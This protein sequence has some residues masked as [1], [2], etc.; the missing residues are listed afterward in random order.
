[1][2]ENGT[3]VVKTCGRDA[4]KIAI[5]IDQVD[6]TYVLIDGQVRRKK[7]NRMHLEPLGK[8]IKIK[9]KATSETVTK[10]LKAFGIE[11]KRRKSKKPAARP[12]KQ[13]KAEKGVEEKKEKLETKKKVTTRK[14]KEVKKIKSKK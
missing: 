10:E 4:G 14:K 13:R 5:V 8:K 2:L 11:V 7:C 6:D 12:K 3:V 1:M 9:P